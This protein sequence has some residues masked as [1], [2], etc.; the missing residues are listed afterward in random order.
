M[1]AHQARAKS[2]LLPTGAPVSSARRLSTTAVNGWLAAR[3]RTPTGIASDGTNVRDRN[4]SRNDRGRVE[5]LAPA[6]LLVTRPM[7]A[8]SQAIAIENAVTIPMTANQSTTEALG[9]NPSMR[10]T[11]VTATV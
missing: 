9:R 8:D 6:T 7:A 2:A 4:G 3:Q 1:A 11:P 5:P 10:A